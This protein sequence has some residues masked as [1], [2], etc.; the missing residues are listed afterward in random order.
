MTPSIAFE[1]SRQYYPRP[2]VAE[3]KEA[4]ELRKVRPDPCIKDRLQINC[5]ILSFSYIELLVS[6]IKS[7]VLH[8]RL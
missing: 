5:F 4:N 6:K 7:F 2:T 3:R 1:T 8:F